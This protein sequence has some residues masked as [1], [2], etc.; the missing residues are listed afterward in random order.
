VN[1]T[2]PRARHAGPIEIDHRRWHDGAQ[3][4]RRVS[5]TRAF[6]PDL[7]AAVGVLRHNNRRKKKLQDDVGFR[8][9]RSSSR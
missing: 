5:A 2:P 1:R 6:L 9:L 4:I 7:G 3:T 8:K